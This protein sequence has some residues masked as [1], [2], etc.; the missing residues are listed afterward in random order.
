MSVY[1]K[2]LV[3]ISL[4]ITLSHVGVVQ[5]ATRVRRDE[6]RTMTDK[7]K[8]DIVKH[9]NVLRAQEDA[10]NMEM[11]TW[12]ESLAAA[13]KD[14]VIKC[15]W[16]HGFPPLP[17]SS[18]TSYG[19]NLYMIG[20][21]PM[22]VVDGVQAWYDEKFDYDYD[23]LGCTAGKLCGHYTQVVW[24]TSRQVGSVVAIEIVNTI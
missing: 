7:Q 11:M 18:F 23:T 4:T 19:Q 3:V 1:M 14:W 6:P 17:G 5:S 22:D 21:A 15:T 24:A 20:G 12:N 8:S 9:H 10:A 2:L 13:A 16:E